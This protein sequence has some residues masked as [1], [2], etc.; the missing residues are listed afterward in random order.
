MKSILSALLILFVFM[1][2]STM[3]V[4]LGNGARAKISRFMAN[5]KISKVT[6]IPE[7]NGAVS[8]EIEGYTSD[9]TEALK[10]AE[11]ALDKL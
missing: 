10:I 1:G 4:S 9:T 2:C 3:D 8:V 5:T 7:D 11:K 6:V